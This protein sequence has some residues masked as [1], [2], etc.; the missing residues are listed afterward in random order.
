[1]AETSENCQQGTQNLAEAKETYSAFI[2]RE[3]VYS[4]ESEIYK[5]FLRCGKGAAEEFQRKTP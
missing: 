5:T 3:G 4:G 2:G 1:M